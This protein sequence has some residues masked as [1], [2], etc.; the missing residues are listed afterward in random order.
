MKDYLRR[1]IIRHFKSHEKTIIDLHPGINVIYGDPQAGKSNIFRA[2]ELLM[3]NRPRGGHFM[4]NFLDKAATEV[5]FI[6]VNKQKVGIKVASHKTKK[7]NKKRDS[8][9]YYTTDL[10]SGSTWDATGVGAAVPEEITKKINL[11]EIN[12]QLQKDPPFLATKSGSKISKTVNRITGLDIGDRLSSTLTTKVNAQNAVVTA[13]QA[14]LD[15][16]KAEKKIFTNIKDIQNTIKRVKALDIQISNTRERLYRL[17][18]AVEECNI[19]KAAYENY[20]MPPDCEESLARVKELTAKI[21][22]AIPKKKA[23]EDALTKK[24]EFNLAKGRLN[25]AVEKYLKRLTELKQ[26]PTC[27]TKVSKATLEHIERRIRGQ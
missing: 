16:L 4:P 13:L 12:V 17:T 2:L 25:I 23:C 3:N 26:C 7:G 8:T 5:A 10:S 24:R 20:R 1:L 6:D 14:K 11:S 9:Y 19:L 18:T 22:A 27:F 15:G 21:K